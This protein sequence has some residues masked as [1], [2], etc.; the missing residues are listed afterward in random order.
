[1]IYAV[2]NRVTPLSGILYIKLCCVLFCLLFYHQFS[3]SP[4]FHCRLD[5]CSLLI[6]L[7]LR[8]VTVRLDEAILRLAVVTVRLDEAVTS[9]AQVIVRLVEVIVLLYAQQ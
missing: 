5:T 3:W 7:Y 1:M 8:L 2:L 4:R 6:I 9:L